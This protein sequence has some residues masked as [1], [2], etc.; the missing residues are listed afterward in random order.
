MTCRI[1]AGIILVTG[2]VYSTP[3]PDLRLKWNSGKLDLDAEN[4]PLSQVLQAIS[5]ETGIEITGAAAPA[6][7]TSAHFAG[8]DLIQV[9]R[10]LLAGVDFAISSGPPVTRVLIIGKAG[11]RARR[12]PAVDT[13]PTVETK[14][15][16]APPEGALKGEA[17]ETPEPLAN[18]P[19]VKLAA[20]GSA[21]T[22]H[23]HD[24]LNAFLRDG[25][26]AVQASAF[27]ALAAQSHD[28]AIDSLT[29]EIQDTS[30]PARLQALQLLVQ[31]SG[32]GDSVI[33]N[34]LL[35]ALKDPDPAFNAY[36]IQTLAGYGNAGALEA[37]SDA[38]H[39]MDAAAKLT[40]VQSLAGTQAGLP[41]LQ[42]AAS[43]ADATVSA[44][45]KELLA[46]L[47]SIH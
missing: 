17:V 31:S 22:D 21:A 35:A 39:G 10:D 34:T 25:D 12:A 9:L 5:S 36:A 7:P 47:T 28:A 26:A 6:D 30:Q 46:Q 45:A 16:A 2:A 29:A 40:I 44:A 24:A 18:S 11:E 4:I 8:A 23:D 42:E 19:E 32:A 15:V 37:L 27:Q 43:D 33:M 1:L 14:P 41:L 3:R 38:F 13:K 20:I